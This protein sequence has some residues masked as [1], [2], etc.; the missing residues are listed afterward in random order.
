MVK[1]M[2]LS[3]VGFDGLQDYRLELWAEKLN[4]AQTREFLNEWTEWTYNVYYKEMFPDGDEETFREAIEG[5]K[6][7]LDQKEQGLVDK[8]KAL[9]NEKQQANNEGVDKT[10]DSIGQISNEENTSEIGE[11]TEQQKDRIELA[12]FETN[13]FED[14][15]IKNNVD[16]EMEKPI[17]EIQIKGD[18]PKEILEE[19]RKEQSMDLWMN[20]F[21]G[22]YSSID[23]VSQAVKVKFVKM[24]SYI[25]KAISE[26]IKERSHKRESNKK[27]DQSER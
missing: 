24:K 17:E 6:R 25:I 21:N 20:R 15:L 1:K 18:S 16:P 14:I 19:Q 23:R 7:T 4:I 11:Q 10:D 8:Y 12:R 5:I 9:E 22:W 27:Q 26:K 2:Y 3:D 13:E